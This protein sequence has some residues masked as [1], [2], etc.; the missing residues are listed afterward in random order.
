MYTYSAITLTLIVSCWNYGW[1][2]ST[3]DR[4]LYNY[5]GIRHFLEV[6]TERGYSNPL[7]HHRIQSNI[8]QIPHAALH[9]R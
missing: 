2:A 6:I 1:F 7:L 5:Q 8:Y 4:T 9:T 3:V